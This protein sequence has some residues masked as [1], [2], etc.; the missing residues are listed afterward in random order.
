MFVA[1]LVVLPGVVLELFCCFSA[2]NE[3]RVREGSVCAC[4]CVGVC[5]RER[6][7]DT[8]DFCHSSCDLQ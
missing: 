5:V 1:D 8:S 7:R 4:V 6:E 3:E 2:P